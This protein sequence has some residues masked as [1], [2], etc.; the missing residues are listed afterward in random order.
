MKDNHLYVYI[1]YIFL[2]VSNNSELP[3]AFMVPLKSQ[4]LCWIQKFSYAEQGKEKKIKHFL[5]WAQISKVNFLRKLQRLDK[6]IPCKLVLPAWITAEF[7]QFALSFRKRLWSAVIN[8][9]T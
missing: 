5:N 8:W 3:T 4:V 1:K 6:A 9:H 7:M 2:L